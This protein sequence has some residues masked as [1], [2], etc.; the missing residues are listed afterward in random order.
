MGDVPGTGREVPGGFLPCFQQLLDLTVVASDDCLRAHVL[1]AQD[2]HMPFK[3]PHLAKAQ[4][5][6]RAKV[7]SANDSKE[8]VGQK[9]AWKWFRHFASNKP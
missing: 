8:V 4:N 5:Q 7:L 6:G 3:T 2:Y 1:K 9:I